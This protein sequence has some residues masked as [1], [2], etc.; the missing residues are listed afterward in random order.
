M[1]K[2]SRHLDFGRMLPADEAGRIAQRLSRLPEVGVVVPNERKRRLNATDPLYLATFSSSGCGGCSR[3][4]AAQPRLEQAAR[5][6]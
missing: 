2:R 1:G 3:L 6:A 5:G 4:A